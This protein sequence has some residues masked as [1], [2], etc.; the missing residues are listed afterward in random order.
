FDAVCGGRLLEARDT[1]FCAPDLCQGPDGSVY[2]CDFHDKRTAHPDPDADWDRSNGRIYKIEAK[3]AKPLPRFD[4]GK[5]SSKELV[6]YLHHPNGWFADQA[7]VLLAGR[8]DRGVWPELRDLA[9]QEKDGRLALQGLWVLHVSGGFDDAIA[10]RLLEHPYEYVRAWT[11]R[12][13]GDENK[14]S[15]ALAKQLAALAEKE[16]S[17]IVRSQL[18]STAKRLPGKDGLPLAEALLLRDLDGADP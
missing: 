16:T 18:A 3:D 14:V 11:V 12:L 1:W 7:R 17:I 10:S 4:L 6:A 8:R 13:L 15:P 9:L 5:K 2:V